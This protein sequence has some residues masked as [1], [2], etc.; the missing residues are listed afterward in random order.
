MGAGK[1]GKAGGAASGVPPAEKVKK[2]TALLTTTETAVN[3]AIT[4]AKKVIENTSAPESQV[5]ASAEA[6]TK[7]Q[8]KLTEMQKSIN[9]DITEIRKAGPSGYTHVTEMQ[10]LLPKVKTLLGQLNAENIKIK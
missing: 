5:K 4:N 1:A 10:K 9:E 8:T 2:A 7:N 3:T 6:M